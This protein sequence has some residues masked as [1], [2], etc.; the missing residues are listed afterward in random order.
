MEIRVGEDRCKEVQECYLT[1]LLGGMGCQ[2][3]SIF[4]EKLS[5]TVRVVSQ[6]I[7]IF[8]LLPSIDSTH[9]P[10]NI[11]AEVIDTSSPWAYFRG[12]SLTSGDYG[13]GEILY[14]QEHHS[15]KI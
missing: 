8:S 14:L 1:Y 5:S 9:A 11:L 6:V 7:S 13:G 3:N 10:C 4:Q 2:N 15:F 12:V